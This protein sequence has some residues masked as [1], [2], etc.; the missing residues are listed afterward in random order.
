M[1]E[2][3]G[4][5]LPYLMTNSTGQ[6]SNNK[7]LFEVN[8]QTLNDLMSTKHKNILINKKVLEFET[9]PEKNRELMN[10]EILKKKIKSENKK[11][12]SSDYLQKNQR[13]VSFKINRPV[14]ISQL[15]E[16]SKKSEAKFEGYAQLNNLRRHNDKYKYKSVDFVNE[17]FIFNDLYT[18]SNENN[19]KNNKKYCK[20]NTNNNS[21]N[22]INNFSDDFRPSLKIPRVYNFFDHSNT[23]CKRN[24]K[25]FINNLNAAS[26]QNNSYINSNSLN[27][28][29]EQ[30]STNK[31]KGPDFEKQLEREIS[32]TKKLKTNHLY[33]PNIV[34]IEHNLN[35]KLL[36]NCNTY[37][38]I[39]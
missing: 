16:D 17:N 39:R 22:Y 38:I 36:N 30:C 25:R 6:I 1:N 19:E 20:N 9:K 11:T 14:N 27:I 32:K 15:I 26:S 29:S 35:K 18:G 37:L 8:T 28:G 10:N 2:R 24:S 31:I 5:I 33:E 7:L 4:L 12:S 23:T 21:N 13:E 34:L 3:Q